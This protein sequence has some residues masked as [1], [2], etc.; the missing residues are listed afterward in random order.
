MADPRKMAAFVGNTDELPPDAKVPV[1]GMPGA[2]DEDFQEGSEGKYGEL[3]PLLEEEAEALEELAGSIDLDPAE[4]LTADE[5]DQ[6]EIDL[7]MEAFDEL[8]PELQEA[9]SATMPTSQK[10]DYEMLAQHLLVEEMIDDDMGVAAL[11][12]LI[13]A[14]LSGAAEDD[15]DAENAEDDEEGDGED[16]E[17]LLDDEE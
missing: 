11:L 10:G 7:A 4:V 17:A 13:A 9:L 5:H 14:G 16:D 2:G 15:E 8:S 6:D 3:I 12:C 1:G